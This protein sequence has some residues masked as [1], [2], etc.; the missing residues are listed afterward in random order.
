VGLPRRYR[1]TYGNFDEDIVTDLAVVS[2]KVPI[3][4]V[5]DDFLIFCRLDWMNLASRMRSA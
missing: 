1:R 4:A 2:K 5:D 3:R